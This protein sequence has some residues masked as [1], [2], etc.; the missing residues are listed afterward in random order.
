MEKPMLVLSRK[1]GERI[2]IGDN[3]TLV[4]NRIAGNR[5]T[6][7][8]EAPTHVRIVRSELAPL[9]APEREPALVGGPAELPPLSFELGEQNDRG[10]IR[11]VP[12]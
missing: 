2:Q 11:R 12:R 3:I 4:I 10:Y 6:L 9:E 5:V 7:G 1:V 8:I